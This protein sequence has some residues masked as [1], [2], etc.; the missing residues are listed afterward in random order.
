LI[1]YSHRIFMYGPVALLALLVAGYS[2]Y[3]QASADALRVG[4]DAA[5]GREIMPGVTF[6]FAEKTVGGYPFRL[7]A[8]LSGVTFAHQGAQ[9]ETAW[10]TEKLALLMQSYG[11]GHFLF[12]A[13][14]LQSFAWPDANGIS[15]VLYVTPGTARASAILEDGK[16]QRFDLDV[17]EAEA[18]DAALSAPPGRN[19]AVKRAQFHLRARED[20]AIDVAIKL[21]GAR[22]GPG[23]TP[24]LGPNLPLFMLKGSLSHGEMLETLLADK[25]SAANACEAWRKAGGAFDVSGL[26]LKWGDTIADATAT[27][28]F[29][30][31]HRVMG[32]IDGFLSGRQALT[33]A[34]QHAV[35][36]PQQERGPADATI[37]VLAAMAAD[38]HGR[39]PMHLVMQNGAMMIGTEQVAAFEP[40]Y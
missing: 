4:L 35:Q 11:A 28:A 40:L 25:D 26:S 13:A 19:V 16:L 10:R 5:N 22:I 6:A 9:G 33:E 31:D 17:A 20:H 24:V 30:G 38:A 7:D 37:S 34:A 36:L 23:F 8:V 29:D 32:A 3:W 12:E 15:R 39:M 2:L 18:K 1:S 21:E 14:G 27:F